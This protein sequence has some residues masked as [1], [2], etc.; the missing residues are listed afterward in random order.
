[1]E[2][3]VNEWRLS[4]ANARI[5]ELQEAAEKGELSDALTAELGTLAES[6][7]NA[8]RSAVRVMVNRTMGES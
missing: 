1:M 6:A 8:W 2:F 4:E 5:G 7:V 3:N